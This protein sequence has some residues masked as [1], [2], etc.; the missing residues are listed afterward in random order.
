L[1]VLFP[2]ELTCWNITGGR[3][4]EVTRKHLLDPT[5]L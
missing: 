3:M 2:K 5:K 1:L 4:A